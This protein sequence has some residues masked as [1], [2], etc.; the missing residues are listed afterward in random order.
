MTHLKETID[1]Y[2]RHTERVTL[3]KGEDTAQRQN[4]A[5]QLQKISDKNGKIFLAILVLGGLIFIGMAVVVIYKLD[6]PDHLKTIFGATGLSLSGII[7]YLHQLWKEKNATDLLITL[8][9]VVE[10]D[11]LKLVLT[12]LLSK[13]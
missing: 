10:K 5:A 8:V 7:W 11:D 3:G 6:E 2:L 9:G 13:I 1:S 4:L 12:A